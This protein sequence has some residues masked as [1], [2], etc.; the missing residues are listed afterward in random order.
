MEFSRWGSRQAV[1][2][3]DGCIG[4]GLKAAQKPARASPDAVQLHPYHKPQKAA[5]RASEAISLKLVFARPEPAAGRDPQ[6]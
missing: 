4:M 6:R 5:L 2:V 3:W 1:S